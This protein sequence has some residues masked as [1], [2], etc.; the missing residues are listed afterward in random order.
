MKIYSIAIHVF[1]IH[2]FSI[3]TVLA[4]PDLKSE[5]ATLQEK[6]KILDDQLKLIPTPTPT[7]PKPAPTPLTINDYYE[8]IVKKAPGEVYSFIEQLKISTFGDKN[9]NK[10]KLN[11]W[12]TF[13]KAAELYFVQ[14]TILED[15]YK[16]NLLIYKNQ[17]ENLQQI[18]NSLIP[19]RKMDPNFVKNQFDIY[20]KSINEIM[21]TAQ[22][23]IVKDPIKSSAVKAWEE[24]YKNKKATSV[25]PKIDEFI[26]EHL[27]NP[28][29][30]TILKYK[31]EK[32]PEIYAVDD[33]LEKLTQVIYVEENTLFL[34]RNTNRLNKSK[35][36]LSS[37]YKKYPYSG[38]LYPY[39]Q[40]KF[41]DSKDKPSMIILAI[42]D[43]LRGALE[44]FKKQL[45][46]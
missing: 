25:F 31:D 44:A 3:F 37:L 1:F 2:S 41:A 6:L 34:L 11:E 38:K 39:V 14:P 24:K 12:N 16:Q 46:R 23:N 17:L 18:T 22:E 26:A 4:N 35:D 45:V 30:G 40:A 19:L 15:F 8:T 32:I 27:L 13:L 21:R 29:M 28:T 9:F 7:P 10:V 5:L 36:I 43:S 33:I 20:L 42:A